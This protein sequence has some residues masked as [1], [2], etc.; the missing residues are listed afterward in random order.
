MDQEVHQVREVN[1]NQVSRSAAGA[2][3]RS[4]PGEKSQSACSRNTSE[5]E[6][7]HA[8]A[9]SKTQKGKEGKE[10]RVL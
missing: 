3:D 6:V 9:K 4:S 8:H 2:A 7:V 1:V 5:P 10:K